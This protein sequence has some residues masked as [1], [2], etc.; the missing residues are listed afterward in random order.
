MRLTYI[1]IQNKKI[2]I[3]NFIL[4]SYSLEKI[5]TIHAYIKHDF[6][7]YIE[8]A[9]ISALSIF[10]NNIENIVN[11]ILIS[12]LLFTYSFG[13]IKK[14][15]FILHLESSSNVRPSLKFEKLFKI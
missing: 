9:N 5:Q 8:P 14:L 12:F 10:I 11:E 13:Y 4:F 1:Y 7:L 15:I 6:K 2:Q 3:D